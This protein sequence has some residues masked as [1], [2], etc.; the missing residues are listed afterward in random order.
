MNDKTM[1]VTKK[2]YGELIGELVLTCGFGYFNLAKDLNEVEDMDDYLIYMTYYLFL[3]KKIVERKYSNKDIDV[4]INEAVNYICKSLSEDKSK[5]MPGDKNLINKILSNLS[6]FD[7]DI[8]L[9]KDLDKL[10]KSF[11]KDW[12]L[13]TSK[14]I[15][16]K[17]FN[18]LLTFII[19][20]TK[21]LLDNNIKVIRAEIVEHE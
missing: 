14:E 1:R 15:D 6:S 18:E 20:H 5:E 7:I 11:E 17:V 16:M 3:S 8:T 4:F 9:M 10:V 2:E 21:S 12:G 13:K 19:N